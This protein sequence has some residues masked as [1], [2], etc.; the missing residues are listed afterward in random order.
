MK[1]VIEC[2]CGDHPEASPL[3]AA[4][5]I[6]TFAISTGG[7]VDRFTPFF[8][9][10][11]NFR[12]RIII[13]I[14]VLFVFSL[15]A[16]WVATKKHRSSSVGTDGPML[17]EFLHFTY[18]RKLRRSAIVAGLI[19]SAMLVFSLSDLRFFKGHNGSVQGKTIGADG[20]EIEG[21][22][23]DALNLD[24]ESVANHAASSDSRGVFVLDL[25]PEKGR[26]AYVSVRS[27]N[28][29][30]LQRTD[31]QFDRYVVSTTEGSANEHPSAELILHVPCAK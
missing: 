20:R 24:E 14:V 15:V 1:S 27:S 26:A 6:L 17:V 21:M 12:L 31:R 11:L 2:D 30:R 18:K 3:A 25:M 10:V 8:A 5:S 22:I 9:G 16:F 19:A 7:A 29:Y 4:A 13:A 28:C 23:V